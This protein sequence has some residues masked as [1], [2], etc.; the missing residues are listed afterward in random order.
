MDFSGEGVPDQGA[1]RR[2]DLREN[3]ADGR[4]VFVPSPDVRLSDR[5]R[6][7]LRDPFADSCFCPALRSLPTS[8]SRKTKGRRERSVLLCSK[9]SLRT[10]ASSVR[11]TESRVDLGAIATTLYAGLEFPG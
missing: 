2:A 5:I 7:C 11:N 9:W 10:K 4:S 6:Q 3:Q 1:V 8:R